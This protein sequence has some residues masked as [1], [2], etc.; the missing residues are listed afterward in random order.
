MA[1]FMMMLIVMLPISFA[2]T[3]TYDNNGNLISG[4]GRYREYN[5]LNQLWRLYNGSDTSLLLEEY[6]YHPTE[7]R[8]LMKKVYNNDSS[9]SETVI[10][11]SG[12][13]VKVV[14]DSGEYDSTYVKH[15]G[16]LVGQLNP[17]GTK[18]FKHSDHLGSVSVLTNEAGEAIENTSYSPYGEIVEGGEQRNNYPTPYSYLKASTGFVLVALQA[19]KKPEIDP[20]KKA[21]AKLPITSQEGV[22]V[23]NKLVPS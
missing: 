12:T 16:Q 9:L 14:N 13:F 7:E 18:Y 6:T 1:I 23:C 8:I 5:S 10:Y 4:D 3:L 11:T 19:G 2:E 15:E 20:I 17:D 22:T 21:N